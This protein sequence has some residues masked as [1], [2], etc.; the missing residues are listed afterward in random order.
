MKI[1]EAIIKLQ[2]ILFPKFY[3]ARDSEDNEYVFLKTNDQMTEFVNKV[4]DKTQLEAFENHVH[5]CG[6]VKKRDRQIAYTTA[7]L[8]TN[9]LMDKLKMEFPDKKFY[10]YLD[11]DFKE[12]IIIRFHQLWENELLCYNVNDFPT[13][14]A[15]KIE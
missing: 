5:V 1:F 14:E 11:C 2:D 9:N 15:Y 8:I 7:K 6:K 12:H 13:I 4:S 10:V 3:T